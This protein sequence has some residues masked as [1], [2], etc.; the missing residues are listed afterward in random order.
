MADIAPLT[1]RTIGVTADRRG[2][3][4]AVLFGRMGADVVLGPTITT[5]RIPDPSLLRQRT[6]EIVADPPDYVIA[7]TGIGMRTWL[8]AAGEWGL[9]AG[10]LGALERSH[11]AARG[12]KV[13][14]A[15]SSAGL[16]AW[17]RSPTEQLSE[18]VDHLRAV[19]L[20][21]CRVAFQLHGDD[22]AEFVARLEAAGARVVTIPVYVWQ[23]PPDPGPALRLIDRTCRGELDA[24]TF[25]AGPQIR[26][27][28]E[29]AAGAGREG[30]LLAALSE[31]RL[32]VG[33]IGPVCAGVAAEAGIRGVVVPEHW[34]LGSLVK[35]VAGALSAPR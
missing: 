4:Q 23:L 22:G 31:G 29:L 32:V 30:D 26:A 13:A 24:L 33:C 2:E 11:L 1:G 21:G 14:G 35:A 28:L 25:T 6:E 34:R 27:M 10:L 15:L 7:N 17:W 8:E 12:P 5:I 16:S 18:L 3:D 20:D 19:G 9:E